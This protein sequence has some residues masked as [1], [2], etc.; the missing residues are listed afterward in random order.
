MQFAKHVTATDEIQRSWQL[1][2]ALCVVVLA[3]IIGTAVLA[4]RNLKQMSEA[5]DGVAH[6]RL[7]D[8]SLTDLMSHMLNAETG[9]RGFLLSGRASYLQ[10]YYVA[11]TEIRT[12]RAA[13]AVTLSNEPSTAW[14]LD[15]LDKTIA[16]KLQELDRSISLKNE[17]RSQEAEELLLAGTGKQAMDAVREAVGVLAASAD[18]RTKQW[19]IEQTQETRNNYWTLLISPRCRPDAPSAYRRCLPC[20]CSRLAIEGWGG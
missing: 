11:L 3:A 1:T 6:A 12:S 7:T 2:L 14:Q 10:P 18:R 8:K 16:A 19:E 4:E 15:T 9:Q 17:G 20:L 5:R 13:L